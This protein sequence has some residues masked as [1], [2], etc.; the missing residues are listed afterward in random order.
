MKSTKNII[1]IVAMTLIVLGQIYYLLTFYK[2][3]KQII[4]A[5]REEIESVQISIQQ[6]E[7]RL[8]KHEESKKELE[9]I[10][11]EKV[12]LEDKIPNQ[13]A[14][15]KFTSEFKDYLKT[16]KSAQV[17]LT[18]SGKEVIT[19]EIGNINKAQYN[20]T[21]VSSYRDSAK[22][23]AHLREMYQTCNILSYTFDTEIQQSRDPALA[24]YFQD[25]FD[26]CGMTTI[27]FEIY[28]RADDTPKDEIYQSE[29]V[30][31][32]NTKPFK[33]EK[34]ETG[35][36]SGNTYNPPSINQGN[37]GGYQDVKP[38]DFILNVGDILTS[39][40]V[41]KLSGPGNVEGDY[42]GLNSKAS[43]DISVT[44]YENS[45]SLK[46]KD[47]NGN[48]Q[49][50]TVDYPIGSP[51]FRIIS[52]MRPLEEVMPS[53]HVY[54]YNYSPAMM[55]VS[56]SGTMLE[57]IHVYNEDEQEVTQGQTKGNI[58]LT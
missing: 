38:A 50:S 56:L 7:E 36:Q 34:A 16:F 58:S 26:S 54:I 19:S 2:E 46:I 14:N 12:A 39:G 23:I 41:Y 40:D 45:Y 55:K 57:N 31:K 42:V 21:F 32:V 24:N 13:D 18:S 15:S 20:L 25:E 5:N 27:D 17:N 48:V 49:E 9:Q 43:V 11:I 4:E 10:M 33:N 29:Y 47:K 8:A 30:A 44:L 6:L 51:S 52:S 35:N 22:F 53:V 37:Q 28:Y 1:F 3:D